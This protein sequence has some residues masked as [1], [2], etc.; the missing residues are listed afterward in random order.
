MTICTRLPVYR[1]FIFALVKYAIC[2][3]VAAEGLHA[4]FD[5]DFLTVRAL[6]WTGPV[7]V[8]S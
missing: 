1:P 3:K 5:H 6:H 8:V 4:M 2:G 7:C